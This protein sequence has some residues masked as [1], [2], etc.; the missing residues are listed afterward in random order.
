M[1]EARPPHLRPGRRGAGDHAGRRPVRRRL[2]HPAHSAVACVLRAAA[3]AFVSL[4]EVARDSTGGMLVSTVDA[5][6]REA[7]SVRFAEAA[8]Q[9][10]PDATVLAVTPLVADE[11]PLGVRLDAIGR[12]TELGGGSGELVTAGIYLVPERVR[13]MGGTPGLG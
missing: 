1:P 12:V 6:C 4:R 13:R 7:D 2:A 8:A 3:P 5:W 10:P 11:S 9:G